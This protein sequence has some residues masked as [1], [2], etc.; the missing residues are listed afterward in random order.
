MVFKLYAQTGMSKVACITDSLHV[1]RQVSEMW[2]SRMVHLVGCQ[3]QVAGNLSSI[4]LLERLGQEEGVCAL[5]TAPVMT[6]HILKAFSWVQVLL[7]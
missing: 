1:G 3:R 4:C 5:H 7:L 6:Q 2:A